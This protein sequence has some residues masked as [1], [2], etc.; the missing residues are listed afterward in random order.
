M[1]RPPRLPWE[2]HPKCTC[3]APTIAVSPVG[4]GV[5]AGRACHECAFGVPETGRERTSTS[6]ASSGG[7]GFGRSIVTVKCVASAEKSSTSLT[8]VSSGMNSSFGSRPSKQNR[9]ERASTR[10]P[11]GALMPRAASDWQARTDMISEVA[12]WRRNKRRTN[13][14]ARLGELGARAEN[15]LA[16]QS[17]LE[18]ER[19]TAG[20]IVVVHVHNPRTAITVWNDSGRARRAGRGIGLAR[21]GLLCRCRYGPFRLARLGRAEKALVLAACG[22]ASEFKQFERRPAVHRLLQMDAHDALPVPRLS[23]AYSLHRVREREHVD[24]RA[25]ALCQERGRTSSSANASNP[26]GSVI[27]QGASISMPSRMSAPRLPLTRTTR[28]WW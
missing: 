9:R 11:S 12:R 10:V 23:R 21:R 26:N 13:L 25:R 18:R 2:V 3:A 22:A 17:E 14:R 8:I 27:S 16:L 20:R 7:E 5:G 6:S 24:M 1:L 15:E 19:G 4:G 28:G